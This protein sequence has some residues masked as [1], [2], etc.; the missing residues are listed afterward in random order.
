[1]NRRR[2]ETHCPPGTEHAIVGG[3]AESCVVL[4][5][6]ARERQPTTGWHYPVN[7]LALRHKAGVNRETRDM[8]EAY[9]DLPDRPT[10]YRGGWLP[11][12]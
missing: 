8:A 1:L 11:A 7:A 9:A 5:L 3:Q 2:G 10:A 4:G 12:H 6:G